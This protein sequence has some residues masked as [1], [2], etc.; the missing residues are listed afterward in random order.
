MDTEERTPWTIEDTISA[1]YIEGLQCQNITGKDIMVE[2]D[3]AGCGVWTLCRNPCC[4]K[5]KLMELAEMDSM[6]DQGKGIT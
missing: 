4:Y 6:V 5:C 1:Q 2:D 3:D